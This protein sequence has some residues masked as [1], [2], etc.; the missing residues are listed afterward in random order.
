MVKH[1]FNLFNSGV[2]V[3][4][5]GIGQA[6]TEELRRAMTDSST[7]NILYTP[8]ASQ[9]DSLHTRLAELLCSIAKIRDVRGTTAQTCCF[10]VWR[11]WWTVSFYYADYKGLNNSKKSASKRNKTFYFV[12]FIPIL[13]RVV[14]FQTVAPFS[15]LG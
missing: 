7:Q 11:I 13:F 10:I 12:A 4:A 1:L 14:N 6:D 3:L 15:V 5:V 9:L 8:D 2:K